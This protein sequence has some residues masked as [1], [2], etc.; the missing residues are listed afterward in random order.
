MNFSDFEIKRLKIIEDRELE[1]KALHGNFR[2]TCCN[3][4]IKKVKKK[5][6]AQKPIRQSARLLEQ[7]S[8]VCLFS[9]PMCD[10]TF[11]ELS[12]EVSKHIKTHI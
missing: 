6:V 7:K 1:F 2:E 10:A 11:K 9:C 8:I 3:Q 4:K 5:P 12:N